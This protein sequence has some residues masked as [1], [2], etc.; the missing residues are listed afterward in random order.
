MGDP[1][2]RSSTNERHTNSDHIYSSLVNI[3]IDWIRGEICEC[4]GNQGDLNE[5]KALETGVKNV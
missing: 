2:K 1:G 4:L 3:I 5:E